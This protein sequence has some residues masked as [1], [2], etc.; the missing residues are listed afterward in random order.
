MRQRSSPPSEDRPKP[1]RGKAL[2]F[3][4]PMPGGGQ[5][6]SRALPATARACAARVSPAQDPR[7][8][9]AAAQMP[10]P[11]DLRPEPRGQAQRQ[12]VDPLF[13]KHLQEQ[14]KNLQ[15][16]LMVAQAAAS[17][18]QLDVGRHLAALNQL[19][20]EQGI[21]RE[22]LET[23]RSSCS[24]HNARV[25]Q[26]HMFSGILD[27]KNAE[28]ATSARM[29]GDIAQSHVPILSWDSINDEDSTW[30]SCIQ[31]LTGIGSAAQLRALYGML[32]WNGQCDLL[33]YWNGKQ[34]MKRMV[35]EATGTVIVSH[36]C[37]LQ[38]SLCKGDAHMDDGGSE[39]D[40][41]F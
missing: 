1:K 41:V 21:M 15:E 2:G 29:L 30:H 40:D 32:D 25:A 26:G 23:L 5:H 19:R 24:S 35:K 39:E 17:N 33:R 22:Q 20:M 27:I 10:R 9:V 11:A 3:L 4:L 37:N 36:L 31:Q 7:E 18:K 28:V 13:V 16:Q 8:R 12:P 38:R 34:S 14:I 6:V